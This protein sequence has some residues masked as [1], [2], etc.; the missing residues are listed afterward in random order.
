[1]P[2]IEA[3]HLNM[4]KLPQFS[5]VKHIRYPVSLMDNPCQLQVQ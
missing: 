2:M 4:T 5:K 3:L 1:M